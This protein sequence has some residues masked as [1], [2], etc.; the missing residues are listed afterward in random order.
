MADTPVTYYADNWVTIQESNSGV[1]A[2]ATFP[3][4]DVVTFDLIH[5]AFEGALSP[6]GHKFAFYDLPFPQNKPRI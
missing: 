4:N 1:Y 5:C 2:A 6:K 3:P